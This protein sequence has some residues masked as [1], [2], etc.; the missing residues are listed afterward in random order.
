MGLNDE[1]FQEIK[2][3]PKVQTFVELLMKVQRSIFNLCSSLTSDA[4]AYMCRTQY[5]NPLT[6]KRQKIGF[7]TVYL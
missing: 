4:I 3:H 1:K 5:F 6:R 7:K 2:W